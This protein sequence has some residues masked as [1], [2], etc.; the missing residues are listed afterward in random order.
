MTP[1]HGEEWKHYFG[2]C[3]TCEFTLT[4]I[5]K[6]KNHKL[7][8]DHCR[9]CNVFVLYQNGTNVIIDHTKDHK[10]LSGMCNIDNE[11]M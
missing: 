4:N 7:N 5:I 6:S 9:F 3:T 2:S 1:L 10:Y 8:T 11:S